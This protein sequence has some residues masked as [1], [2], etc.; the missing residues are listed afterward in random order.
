MR[1]IVL[2]VAL[3]YSIVAVLTEPELTL[4]SECWN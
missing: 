3:T 2:E 1:A 4:V